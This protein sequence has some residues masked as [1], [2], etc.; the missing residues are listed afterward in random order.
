MQNLRDDTQS[1][2]EE[3]LLDLAGIMSEA[4]H[5]QEYAPESGKQLEEEVRQRINKL[6]KPISVPDSCAI[7]APAVAILNSIQGGPTVQLKDTAKSPN[8]VNAAAHVERMH[9][10][11][12]ARS[13]VLA[14]DMMESVTPQNSIERDLCIQ[15]A[16]ANSLCMK[17]LGKSLDLMHRSELQHDARKEAISPIVATDAARYANLGI[18]LMK[19]YQ[20]GVF[21]L[22]KLR[23]G[24]QQRVNVVHQHVQ[25]AGGNVAVAGN[26]TGRGGLENGE[27]KKK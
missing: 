20:D 7:G 22:A 6:A 16:A 12:D 10:S 5:L 8:I 27:E 24:G 4:K 11:K 21:A 19:S 1:L 18:R 9:L 25:V 17:F 15:L 2:I 3:E 14:A 13:T 23:G 26:F